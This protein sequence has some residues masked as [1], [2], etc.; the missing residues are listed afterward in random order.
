[1][2]WDKLLSGKFWVVIC[3]TITYC[4]IVMYAT[5]QYLAKSSPD[6]IEG[7]CIGLVMGF[8][9]MAGIVYKSYFERKKEGDE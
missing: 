2:K 9:T 6:K 4:V 7:F 5:I 1:M 8:A 3:T